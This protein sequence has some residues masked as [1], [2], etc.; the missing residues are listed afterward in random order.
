MVTRSLPT[1]TNRPARSLPIFLWRLLIVAS[2]LLAILSARIVSCI[3]FQAHRRKSRY[4]RHENDRLFRPENALRNAKR[5]HLHMQTQPTRYVTD[6]RR[7]SV[8]GL[9]LAL[10]LEVMVRR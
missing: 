4:M 3:H 7:A 9:K 2:L 1:R 5:K 8:I 10:S 6:K